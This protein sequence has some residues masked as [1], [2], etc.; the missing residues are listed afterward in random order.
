MKTIRFLSWDSHKEE[1]DV[2]AAVRK[3][4]PLDSSDPVIEVQTPEELRLKLLEPAYV[5]ILS[6][7]G[8][9][10]PK[11]NGGGHEW[12]LS[13]REGVPAMT[14]D[15]LLLPTD[16]LGAEV[17]ILAT[18]YGQADL[19]ARYLRRGAIAISR[20]GILRHSAAKYLIPEFLAKLRA[21]EFA[22]A[23]CVEAVWKKSNED[24]AA[25]ARTLHRSVYAYEYATP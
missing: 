6:A 14:V 9:L 18:C 4:L 24:A 7:H 19:W 10:C 22:A 25:R 16:V 13:G 23:C 3:E 2:I 1:Q 5:T 11:P 17:F 21:P 8:W 12:K 15:E 20:E